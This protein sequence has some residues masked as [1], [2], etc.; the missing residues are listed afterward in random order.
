MSRK[1]K[2][3]DLTESER[4]TLREGSKHHPKSEFRGK[5]QALLLNHSGLPIRQIAFYLGVNHNSLGNWIKAWEKVGIV[6]LSR[7]TGQGR[8]PILSVQNSRHVKV[9]D[10]AV[11]AHS[12]NVRAIQAELIQ[13]LDQ[14]MSPDTVKRF[15]K[16]II[17][18]GDASAGVAI[19]GK[20]K[21]SM[22]ISTSVGKC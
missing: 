19:K 17:T 6:G 4:I 1:T 3:I 10:Q 5:C 18:L 14:P 15:L 20:T 9:L 11:E 2:Y 7:K 21:R 13:A 22:P 16:R 12:Q 8:K